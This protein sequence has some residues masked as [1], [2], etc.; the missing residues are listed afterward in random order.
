M[1]LIRSCFNKIMSSLTKETARNESLRII[2]VDLEMTGLDIEKDHIL[3]MACLITD[4]KL[5]LIEKVIL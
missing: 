3:E 4:E 1:R 5:E 2:W